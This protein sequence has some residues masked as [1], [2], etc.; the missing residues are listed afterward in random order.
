MYIEFQIPDFGRGAGY[1]LAKIKEQ[2][3]HWSQT[4]NIPYTS[5]TIKYTHRICFDR[6][7]LYT[8]FSITWNPKGASPQWRIVSDLNNKT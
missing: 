7:E 4:H 3:E 1:V 6:D 2:V 5:K 8:F